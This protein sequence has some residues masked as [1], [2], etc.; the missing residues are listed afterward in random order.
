MDFFGRR[1][2]RALQDLTLTVRR[3]EVFG[4][5]GPNG[6][7][8]TTTMKLLLGLIFPT[9]GEARVLGRPSH[10]V[11]AKHQIG[12]LPEESYLYRFLN[13]EETLDFYGQIFGIPKIERRERA[14]ELIKLL[15]LDA[16]R[17][18]PI[19]EYSKGMARRIGFAQALI[20]NPEVLFLDEPTSG[21][22]PIGSREMKDLILKLK[23]EGKTILLSSHLL[24]DVEDV[25]DRIAILHLGKLRR[26]GQVSD[27][28]RLKDVLEVHIR[29]LDDENREKMANLIAEGGG[30]IIRQENP[31]DTLESLFLKTIRENPDLEPEVHRPEWE[32]GSE[33]DDD[34]SDSPDDAS[35][36]QSDQEPEGETGEPPSA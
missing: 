36:G 20:N 25:C 31:S 1:E 15:G 4:L 2:V 29:G 22:D 27:L 6:S 33:E 12:F 7:G 19:R 9:S 32:R 14:D 28:L 13:A 34:E 23:S 17:K 21:L 8:K 16:A 10:D 26:L 35:D 30:E 24:A 3:G 5:L 18:R 11:K